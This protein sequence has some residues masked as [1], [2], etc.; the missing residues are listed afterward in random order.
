MKISAIK[1]Q[2]KRAD[3][4]SIY[5][6]GSY[7]FSL[8]EAELLKLGIHSGQEITDEQITEY[9]GA[10]AYGKLFDKILN[11]LSFRLRSEWE[12]RDYLR[13]KEAEPEVVDAIIE[14]LRRNGYVD[15]EQF[16]RRW[17]ENRHLLKPTSNRKLSLELRQKRIPNDVI[18][19]VLATDE[20]DE[21]STL[22]LVVEK[23]RHRYPDT[24]KFVQY[25]ARQGYG[26]QDIKTVLSEIDAE[27]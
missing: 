19:R 12:L 10:S 9:Q 1:Q 14:R 24:N 25:L 22:R 17:I 8:G 3:R 2:V 13:R 6:D 23:K 15:D 27:A 7:S 5:V 26:Y 4:Y 20:T 16:A 11:L 18:A 21:L